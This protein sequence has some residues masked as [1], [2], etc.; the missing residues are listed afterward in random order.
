LSVEAAQVGGALASLGLAALIVARP[1]QARVAGL[2]AWAIGSVLLALY[3]APS[4]HHRVL[5]AAAVVG[6]V[7]T[8]ALAYVFRRWPWALA[9]A[10]L[11][12][13]PARIPVHVG[14][15]EANLLVPL[16][17][18]VAA[19]ALLLAWELVRGE[20]RARELGRLAWPLGAYVAWT[21]LSLLWS[22]DAHQGAIAVLF[23]YLPF[24]L[25]AVSLARLPWRPRMVV[26]LFAEL[27]AMA[28]AFAGI[29]VY[30]W[31]TRD[32]FWNPKVI[33]GNAYAPFF[34][35]NSVFY[36]PS[37]YGRFL[38]V[39]IA[40]CLVVALHSRVPW[41][42]YAS[43]AAI[44]AA[45]T[46]LLFS[47]SQ[48]SFAALVAVVLILAA[49]LWRWKAALAVA[50]VAVVVVGAGVSAPRVRSSIV[51]HSRSGL[52]H[53]TSGRWK[54]VTNGVK[55]AI[56]HPVSGVGIGD[57]KHAY[58]KQVGLRGREPNSAASHDT[59]VTVAAELGVPGLALLV[60]LVATAL[61]LTLR[62][63][64]PKKLTGRTVLACGVALAAIAVHSLFYNAFFEDPT[65]W[66]L[67]GLA[68][69][70]V[71]VRDASN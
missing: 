51:R 40:A 3:L 71:R 8:V 36:D 61:M 20:H 28:V 60:W 30:Q 24:G 18:V 69:L 56:H 70:A 37:V 27:G 9:G 34:R 49:R 63:F 14:G 7:L 31:A 25:L 45:W 33:V 65:T 26:W 54:L 2:G 66:G 58:A 19:A 39:A 68:A 41:V 43:G 5:V 50:L 16:Y 21:G 55:V 44:V 29:G 17:A 57:F 15:T 59:P 67:L 1:R 4:S 64:S 6:L 22:G 53:A 48:S 38:V 35:V 11:A 10:A 23:F 47:F 13:V 62:R 52:N 42:A 32:I 12:C 46:G